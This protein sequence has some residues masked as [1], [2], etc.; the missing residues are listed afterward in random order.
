[1][2]FTLEEWQRINS[3][4]AHDPRCLKTVQGPKLVLLLSTRSGHLSPAEPAVQSDAQPGLTRRC[5]EHH[6]AFKRELRAALFSLVSETRCPTRL[7]RPD[8]S[9]FTG[10]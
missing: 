8:I 3:D 9:D 4:L 10:A 2:A 7:V 6:T 1:M 5:S